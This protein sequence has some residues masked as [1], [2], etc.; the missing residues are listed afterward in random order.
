MKTGK[1][2]PGLKQSVLAR[3]HETRV[4]RVVLQGERKGGDRGRGEGEEPCHDDWEINGAI[5]QEVN[6]CTQPQ[7]VARVLAGVRVCVRAD[8]C[9]RSHLY[10]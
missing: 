7:E 6:T 9:G 3:R 4:E 10:H 1:S 8:V 2:S 5:N